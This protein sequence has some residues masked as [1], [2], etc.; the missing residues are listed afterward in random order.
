[1]V[2]ALVVVVLSFIMGYSLR[3]TQEYASR[4]DAHQRAYLESVRD[5][6]EALYQ[7]RAGD[8]DSVANGAQWDD[9]ALWLERANIQS[10]WNLQLQVSSSIVDTYTGQSFRRLV[11]YLPSELHELNPPAWDVA[12][13]VFVGCSNS[14][15]ECQVPEFLLVTG[16]EI[17]RK[18]YER[19]HKQLVQVAT[20]ATSLFKTRMLNTPGTTIDFNH[21]RPAHG[22]C[23]IA[24]TTIMP[25]LDD[26]LA[27]DGTDQAAATVRHLL[28][29]TR[30]G[31]LN[32]WG[33]PIQASNLVDSNAGP[34]NPLGFEPFSMSFR[35]QLPSGEFIRIAAIQPL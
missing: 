33:H 13:G 11:V 2:V 9:P 24:N 28:G 8:I 21:F 3:A 32:P 19:A 4:I 34:F 7:E 1:M 29:L 23:G 35:T 5:Q 25:C 16:Q 12:N 31:V 17:Q 10:R 18:N 30:E 27:L 22:Q 15:E 20:K 26:Y 6:L 14:E